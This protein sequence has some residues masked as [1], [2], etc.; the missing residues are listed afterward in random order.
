MRMESTLVVV[1]NRL[2]NDTGRLPKRSKI[3]TRNYKF[4]GT[5]TLRRNI[6]GDFFLWVK[7]TR[8]KGLG[9]G[10]RKLPGSE[11]PRHTLSKW[12]YR[13]IPIRDNEEIL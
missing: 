6:L 11:A 3:G 2:E 8:Y 1:E 12:E 9:E 13:S 10:E 4:R 7:V 5:S